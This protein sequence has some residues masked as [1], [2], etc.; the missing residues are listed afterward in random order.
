M[1]GEDAGRGPPRAT[2]TKDTEGGAGGRLQ[3]VQ[4]AAELAGVRSQAREL[5][6]RQ[7]SVGRRA[8]GSPHCWHLPQPHPGGVVVHHH[9]RE[10]MAL[11][12]LVLCPHKHLDHFLGDVEGVGFG[13]GKAQ[14]VGQSGSPQ[15]AMKSW[16]AC[17]AA[18][19][20]WRPATNL[21]C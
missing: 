2:A 8:P 9:Q 11:V 21:A 7:A 16:G 18:G 20:R 17:H 19:G 3:V 13:A 14:R 15:P 6:G 10:L 12:D 4:A 5:Q 1:P